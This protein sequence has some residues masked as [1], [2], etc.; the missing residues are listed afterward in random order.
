MDQKCLTSGEIKP[1]RPAPWL[2]H[3]NT[4]IAD[5]TDGWVPTGFVVAGNPQIAEPVAQIAEPIAVA[6]DL[7][8]AQPALTQ[9]TVPFAEP[10]EMPA[11]SY[12]A[13]LPSSYLAPAATFHQAAHVPMGS[14]VQP[15]NVPLAAPAG[16][17]LN[18]YYYQPQVDQPLLRAT[19]V[20]GGKFW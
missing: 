1:L 13:P 14:L 10:V 15:V 12:L 9:A 2:G 19:E 4:R 20:T 7:A 5:P 11:G 16:A 3:G 6:V 8:A 17:G 18:A